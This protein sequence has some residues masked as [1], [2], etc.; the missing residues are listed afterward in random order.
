MHLDQPSAT[1][2]LAGPDHHP[3]R[4]PVF[5]ASFSSFDRARPHIPSASAHAGQDA[6]IQTGRLKPG[7]ECRRRGVGESIVCRRDDAGQV[8]LRHLLWPI[9]NVIDRRR[10]RLGQVYRASNLRRASCWRRGL[11]RRRTESA[12]PLLRVVGLHLA[13]QEAQKE[14]VVWPWTPCTADGCRPTAC[15]VCHSPESV[16]INQ[17]RWRYP[18]LDLKFTSWAL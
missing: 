12:V 15:G 10:R 13:M 7:F 6:A 2:R 4:Q 5:W 8:N 18:A 11:S 9:V 16:H 17:C 1:H 14:T 3:I